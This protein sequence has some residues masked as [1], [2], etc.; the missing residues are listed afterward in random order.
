MREDFLDYEIIEC[1]ARHADELLAL[2]K[3]T[4]IEAF[5]KVSDPANFKLY[6]EQTFT[7]SV[8]AEEL[9]HKESIFFIIRT[10]ENENAGYIKLRWDRGKEFFPNEESIELQRIYV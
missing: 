4:F 9:A 5:E 10:A 3:Q 1:N 6:V 8:I 7:P 2:A